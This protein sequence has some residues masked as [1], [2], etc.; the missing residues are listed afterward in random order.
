MS[1]ESK[2]ARIIK[3]EEKRGRSWSNRALKK[4][5]ADYAAEAE[6]HDKKKRVAAQL[7]SGTVICRKKGFKTPEAAAS[8]LEQMAAVTQIAEATA[9]PVRAYHCV[10]CSRWHLTHPP[11]RGG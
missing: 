3:D 8:A 9:R 7:A 2:R 5:D 10:H 4:L 11:A 6:Y 1:Y